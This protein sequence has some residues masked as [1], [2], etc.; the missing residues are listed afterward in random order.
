[1]HIKKVLKAVIT[2][3]LAGI[4]V[5]SFFGCKEEEVINTHLPKQYEN[6]VY[7]FDQG[8]KEGWTLT[9]E[10]D[11]KYTNEKEALVVRLT[12]DSDPTSGRYSVY[13]QKEHD[14]IPMTSSLQ[15]TYKL[16]TDPECEL[17]FNTRMGVRENF[18]I[19]NAEPLS[20]VY[21]GYQFFSATYTFTEDG[22]DWQGQFYL[23]M[24]SRQYYVI[25]YEAAVAKWVEFEPDFLDMIKDWWAKG[26]ESDDSVS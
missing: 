13:K 18:K 5:F 8:F 19:T 7:Y 22:V 16:V 21:N 10:E 9:G 20:I 6:W 1:M 3:C 15:A 4:M 17:Y 26:Y 14:L 25:A 23:L 11:G 12:K 2:G 24:H